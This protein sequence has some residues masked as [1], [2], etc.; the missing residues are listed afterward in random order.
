MP[1]GNMDPHKG[2]KSTRNSNYVGKYAQYFYYFFL[3]GNLLYK[4]K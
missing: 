2:I 4:H 3:K 1:D